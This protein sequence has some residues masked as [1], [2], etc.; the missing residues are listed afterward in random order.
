MQLDILKIRQIVFR[1]IRLLLFIDFHHIILR[2]LDE[3]NNI[4][5][6][7]FTSFRRIFSC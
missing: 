6:F 2:H 4:L 1:F 7:Y 5:M 3:V